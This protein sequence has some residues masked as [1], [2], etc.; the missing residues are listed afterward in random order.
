MKKRNDHS[1]I[2]KGIRGLMFAAI[3]AA[4]ANVLSI[5]PLAVPIVIGPFESAIH[6]SQ[7]PIILS[8]ILAGPLM[9][10]I[11][12][13]VGGIYMATTRI[14]FIIG[15]LA[16]LG[17]AAGLLGRRL[18]PV[19]AGVLAGLIQ[20]PYVFFTDYTW[21]TTFLHMDPNVAM[22]VI[23]PI[24]LILAIEAFVCAFLAQ[25]VITYLR[26]VKLIIS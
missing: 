7:L 15:G 2:L 4:L 16:V 20:L 12:G 13:A 26:H 18:K 9:G 17:Y 6:F 8:G 11:T 14:P 25:I 3:M 22:G 1:S 5:P 24:I 10:L 19:L 23:W 21:F